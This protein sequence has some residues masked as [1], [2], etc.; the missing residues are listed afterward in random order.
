MSFTPV[1]EFILHHL[2][3]SLAWLA[4]FVLFIRWLLGRWAMRL[5]AKR[6]FRLKFPASP[7]AFLNRKV[8]IESLVNSAEIQ[9]AIRQNAS[10]SDD[11]LEL[12]EK[13]VRA[14]AEEIVPAFSVVYYFAIGYWMARTLLRTFYQVRMVRDAQQ[15]YEKIGPD[16]TVVM[17]MN[18]RSNM[19]VLL[20][21]YLLSNRSTVSHAAGEWARLWPLNHLVKLAGNY[22]VDR[23]SSDPLYRLVLRRYV[24]MS[25]SY[26]IHLG[27]FPEGGLSRDGSVQEL[28]F[29]LLNYVATASWPG[30]DRDIV[31]IPVSF[32]YDLIPEQERLVFEDQREFRERGKLYVACSSFMF[33]L[34]TLWLLVTPRDKRF[35]WACASFGKPLS[36]KNWQR[37]RGINLTEMTRGQRRQQVDEL[38][39]ELMFAALDMIPVLPVHILAITLQEHSRSKWT[40][41]DLLASAEHFAAA[42]NDA[43][44]PLFFYEKPRE[45]AYKLALN[46]LLKLD[47]V[48]RN[49][50]ASLSLVTERSAMLD[51]YTN[52]VAHYLQPRKLNDTQ[53]VHFLDSDP[54]KTRISRHLAVMSESYDRVLSKPHAGESFFEGF[55]SLFLNHSATIS[56]KFS[57]TDMR[58]QQAHLQLSVE[59]MADFFVTRKPSGRLRQI[60]SSHSQS[61]RDIT[62]ELYAVWLRCLLDTVARFDDA[63]SPLVQQSWHAVMQPGIEYMQGQYRRSASTGSLPPASMHHQIDG[64]N[65]WLDQWAL[66]TPDKLAVK[67]ERH[68]YTYSELADNAARLASGLRHGLDVQPGDR[69]AYLALNRVEFI[70]LI[71]A[72]AQTGAILVPINFRLAVEEQACL[73][74]RAEVKA[75]FVAQEFASVVASCGTDY[76]CINLDACVT[77]DKNTA[78]NNTL[79]YQTLLNEHARLKSQ[80]GSLE[81]PL[82]IVFTSGSTGE[83]KGAVLTQGAVHW[84]ALN[85]RLMHDMNRSDH[86]ATTLPFFHVGGINIQSLP[87][88]QVGAT[89]SVFSNFEPATF[90]DFLQQQKPTLTVLVPSQMQQLMELPGWLG[91]DMSS[92]KAVATGSA[93]VSKDLIRAWANKGVPVI[94]IYG[95]T[96]SCPIAIHQTVDGIGPGLGTVGHPALYT[97]VCILNQQGEAVG[98]GCE[99]EV[100][101]KGPNLMS[102][103][104]R[105][106]AASQATFR[107]GWLLT[108]DLGY[109]DGNGRLCIVGRKKQLIISGGENIHPVEIERV[110]E[111]HDDVRE[112]AVVGV[113]DPKWGEVP[114]AAISTVSGEAIPEE[115]M[116]AHL[117]QHLGRFKHPRHILLLDDLPR[118]AL[119]KVA[120]S[121]VTEFVKQR[122]N[123]RT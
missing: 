40:E 110:L 77:T 9:T 60:A 108:G 68:G 6:S 52:S 81:S 99:G 88:L 36:L 38:G 71:F 97:D 93:I 63:F 27:V 109:Q 95:C 57:G 85:S 103:Y 84:N 73:I 51:Y 7:M 35:G 66:R 111:Q 25:V 42:F 32:N 22:V 11:H 106:E 43:G 72:C 37:A 53:D 58:A 41:A 82:F 112:A 121:Q 70:V 102:H 120:Y 80:Y 116:Q 19:D 14:Y 69:V 50:D 49:D 16:A 118:T 4:L 61:G 100:A 107:N 86:V 48:C 113:D 62:P 76:R 45:A 64:I 47:V 122:L 98:P 3:P 92:L 23:E 91:T 1:A 83:P 55:Y 123:M 8:I 114:V 104:W 101:L 94:Q 65:R 44:A 2:L 75:L 21:N 13:R 34:K 30:Q 96:E 87:A 10:K 54:V 28:Y 117:K 74:D 24:Q 115:A 56:D 15:E 26:G 90:M 39:R 67:G 59:H 78:D 105:D 79:A 18:H 5:T 89:V 119:G 20:V 29:G 46:R 17:L 31:F 12:I 33:C